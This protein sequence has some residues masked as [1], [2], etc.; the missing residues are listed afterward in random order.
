MKAFLALA[1]LIL[2]LGAANALLK[3]LFTTTCLDGS[4][5]SKPCS[6]WVPG[7]CPAGE[8]CYAPTDAGVCCPAWTHGGK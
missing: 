1:C 6:G 8:T 2:L 3:D 7:T 5:G 4:T